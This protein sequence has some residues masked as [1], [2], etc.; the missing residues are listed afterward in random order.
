MSY[1]K[2]ALIVSDNRIPALGSDTSH[3][4]FAAPAGGATDGR[5]VVNRGK[6]TGN[7]PGHVLRRA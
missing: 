2:Q 4:T 6:H 1:W 7:R 3:Y 5:I